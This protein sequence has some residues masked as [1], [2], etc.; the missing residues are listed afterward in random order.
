MESHNLD[1][2]RDVRTLAEFLKKNGFSV[3]SKMAQADEP[4][5]MLYAAR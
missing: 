2:E 3:T 5:G 4:V 1:A